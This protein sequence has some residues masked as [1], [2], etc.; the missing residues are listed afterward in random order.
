[1]NVLVLGSRIIGP[2]MAQDVVEAY[3]NAKFSNEE[4]HLRRLNKVKAIE[5]REFR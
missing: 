5:Q 2:M 3:L 1:M 4:R